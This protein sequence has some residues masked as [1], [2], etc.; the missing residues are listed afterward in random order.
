M[1]TETKNL[2][3]KLS[4]VNSKKQTSWNKVSIKCIK[5]GIVEPLSDQGL[6]QAIDRLGYEIATDGQWCALS[7]LSDIECDKVLDQRIR[8][9]DNIIHIIALASGV[10]PTSIDYAVGIRSDYYIGLYIDKIN[11]DIN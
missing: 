9:M 3:I 1:Q 6:L 11:K 10:H 5:Q 2:I 4:P 8:E 7:G